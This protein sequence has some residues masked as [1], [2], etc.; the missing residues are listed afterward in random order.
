VS[1]EVRCLAEAVDGWARTGPIAAVVRMAKPDLVYVQ[2][3]SMV[4]AIERLSA[5]HT[6][7][8]IYVD[9]AADLSAVRM[10]SSAHLESGR[11]EI[12]DS[13]FVWSAG[14]PLFDEVVRPLPASTELF[15]HALFEALGVD[16]GTGCPVCRLIG[17]SELWTRDRVGPALHAVALRS[18][19]RGLQAGQLDA[20]LGLGRGLTPET[21]D[22]LCGA[23][24]AQHAVGIVVADALA[25]PELEARS[26]ATTAL[27]STWLR[28]AAAGR[29]VAPLLGV[30]S[31]AP[32]SPSWR[33]AVR[34]LLGVGA[35]TGRSMLVGATLGLVGRTRRSAIIGCEQTA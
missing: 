13:H 20:L 29:P 17:S 2:V 31:A 4:V 16:P 35:T 11:L 7:N 28:L 9:D 30:L 1:I 14:T 22:L 5:P 10:G 6:P 24:A 25:V 27:S 34:E 33:H 21:D 15:T 26:D 18:A 32:G 12:G 23:L 19:S 3:E 8:G